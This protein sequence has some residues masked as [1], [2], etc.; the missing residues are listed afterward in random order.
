MRRFIRVK[1][2]FPAGDT[3][4]LVPDD[5]VEGWWTATSDKKNAHEFKN[6][7][8]VFTTLLKIGGIWMNSGKL[9]HVRAWPKTAN[10][11]L[12]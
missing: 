6:K 9:V 11:S 4:W 12:S 1:Y 3:V 10:S 2:T 7:R 5:K 8:E